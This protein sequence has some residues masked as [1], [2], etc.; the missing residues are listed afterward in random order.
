MRHIWLR[1]GGFAV[2]QR[3]T[4]KVKDYRIKRG[5]ITPC[6]VIVKEH[7]KL[8]ESS[9]EDLNSIVTCGNCGHKV[10]DTIICLYCAVQRHPLGW[11]KTG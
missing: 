6:H 7:K 8:D 9:E 11:M 3:C 5:G 1:K 4:I 2:C 10:P